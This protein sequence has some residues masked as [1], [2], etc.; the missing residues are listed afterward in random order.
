MSSKKHPDKD[1]P[2]QRQAETLQK[3]GEES[4]PRPAQASG[5]RVKQIEQHRETEEEQLQI[6]SP[7]SI[8]H[9][10]ASQESAG[11]LADREYHLGMFLPVFIMPEGTGDRLVKLILLIFMGKPSVAHQEAPPKKTFLAPAMNTYIIGN[12]TQKI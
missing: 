9:N 2:A 6:P 8:A 4:P 1:P 11:T 5:Q 12:S 7:D 10:H 3:I